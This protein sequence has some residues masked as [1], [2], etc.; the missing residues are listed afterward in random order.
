MGRYAS[1]GNYPPAQHRNVR[2]L[3]WRC[4]PLPV[5]DDGSTLLPRGLGRSYGDSCLNDGGTL[6]DA[7][8]L[9]HL[10]DFDR[11]SGVVRCEAGTSLEGLL[12]VAVPAGFGTGATTSRLAYRVQPTMPIVDRSRGS[13][14]APHC[15][16]ETPIAIADALPGGRLSIEILKSSPSHGRPRGVVRIAGTPALPGQPAPNVECVAG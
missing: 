15:V 12:Q 11:A 4:D 16:L 5:S 13:M 2:T 9:D 3:R 7:T 14:A 1:W 8:R 6:I 10:I